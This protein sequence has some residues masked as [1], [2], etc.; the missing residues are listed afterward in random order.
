MT[1][2]RSR[3]IHCASNST[4]H[5]AYYST[6]AL[7]IVPAAGALLNSTSDKASGGGAA[8]L[9][10]SSL[11]LS[12][13]T[14]FVGCSAQSGGG[15]SALYGSSLTAR[16]A[17][18][19]YCVAILGGA[20]AAWNHS[21]ALI[22][23]SAV[24]DCFSYGPGAGLS[25]KWFA[26]ASV[27]RSFFSGGQSGSDGSCAHI[28]RG[29][30]LNFTDSTCRDGLVWRDGNAG[31]GLSSAR[32]LAAQPPRR[33]C[34]LPGL[35]RLRC[36]PAPPRL[37]AV[38]FFSSHD[39]RFPQPSVPAPPGWYA[40]MVVNGSRVLNNAA[41][42]GAGG[43]FIW[44]SWGVLSHSEVSGNQALQGSAG[45][46]VFVQGGAGGGRC[47][48]GA[49]GCP[50]ASLAVDS[51]V[52]RNNSADSFGGGVAAASAS[53]SAVNATFE[54]N[55]AGRDGGGIFSG[56]ADAPL[57][58]RGGAF[59][60]NTAGRAGGAVAL[61]S[62]AALDV[63]GTN[64]TG[65]AARGGD[66]GAVAVA[67]PGSQPDVCVMGQTR[68]LSGARGR[69]A[70]ATGAVPTSNSFQC[71][72]AISADAMGPGCVLEARAATTALHH[73]ACLPERFRPL[74]VYSLSTL[75]FPKLSFQRL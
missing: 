33:C 71:D 59:T 46:G 30:V 38:Y 61:L 67:Q 31:G 8:A 39:A 28:W 11:V 27:R 51:S 20:V 66:G 56:S 64:F 53:V 62:G 47:S 44:H 15:A 18:F 37:S 58:L 70:V 40:G 7:Y 25:L 21:L 3:D 23:Q 73:T 26:D 5:M 69:I 19:S 49:L 54:G 75:F 29:G 22:D 65:N 14:A 72:W 36:S 60:N 4:E 57:A 9:F 6:P 32:P 12:A 24:S 48:P 10:N 17:A 63:E 74:L 42:A 2:A 45:G 41:P 34:G 50:Y 13:G 52:L 68:R 43:V 16:G 55:F 1:E 35:R